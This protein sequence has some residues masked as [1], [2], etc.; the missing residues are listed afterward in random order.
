[1]CSEFCKTWADPACDKW[2]GDSLASSVSDPP[3]SEL[4][5]MWG[6]GSCTTTDWDAS[7]ILQEPDVYPEV[8]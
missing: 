5:E 4:V 6:D 8:F 7:S 3:F 1:M 2:W